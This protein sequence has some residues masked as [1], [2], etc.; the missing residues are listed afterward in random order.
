MPFL[1]S[2]PEGTVPGVP[3]PLTLPALWMVGSLCIPS[4]PPAARCPA[5]PIQY[6]LASHAAPSAAHPPMQHVPC[7]TSCLTA[8]WC[9]AQGTAHPAPH[10]MLSTGHAVPRCWLSQHRGATRPAAPLQLSGVAAIH[11]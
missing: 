2:L 4:V 5:H 1:S 10:A 9:P 8:V 11:R 7:D 3:Y 6:N